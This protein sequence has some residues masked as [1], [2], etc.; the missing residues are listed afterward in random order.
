MCERRYQCWSSSVY[1]L[2][3]SGLESLLLCATSSYL[4]KFH[5]CPQMRIAHASLTFPYCNFLWIFPDMYPSWPFFLFF[6]IPLNPSSATICLPKCGKILLACVRGC[7]CMCDW[8][9]VR[10]VLCKEFFTFRCLYFYSSGMDGK[11]DL[12]ASE[13]L[14]HLQ[15]KDCYN[16]TLHRLRMLL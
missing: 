10:F 15:R 14:S 11:R 9:Q 16:S 4:W 2:Q 8:K 5:K 6:Y 1:P 3:Y 12:M 13:S 7:F